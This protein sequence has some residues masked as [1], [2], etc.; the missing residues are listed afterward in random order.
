MRVF[1]PE[2]VPFDRAD[3]ELIVGRI[4]GVVRAVFAEKINLDVCR[5]V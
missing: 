5:F 3:E 4:G 2:S 1:V